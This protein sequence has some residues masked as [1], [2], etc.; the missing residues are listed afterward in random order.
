MLLTFVLDC[1]D[2]DRLADFWTAALHYRRLPAEEP[3]VALA[4][5]PDAG[6]EGPV[7]L[8]QRVAEPKA[9][10]NRMHLDIHTDALEAEV[11]RVR[12]LGASVI[13][14]EPSEAHGFRWLVMADPE[15]NEF[16]VCMQ[17]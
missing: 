1:N 3:Y 12:E 14:P 9:G 2:P 5:D 13:G 17:C 15:G 10:K 11:E 7:L 8:L 16:C 6:G 4:P